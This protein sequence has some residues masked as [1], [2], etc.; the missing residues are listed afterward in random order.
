M[1]EAVGT[2]R[3]SGGRGQ[4]LPHLLPTCGPV[5]CT[6][7]LASAGSAPRVLREPW[8]QRGLG[9]APTASL[10]PGKAEVDSAG[11]SA[12]SLLERPQEATQLIPLPPDKTLQL[13][14][15]DSALCVIVREDSVILLWRNTSCKESCFSPQRE[16]PRR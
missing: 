8:K 14:P 2:L 12:T 5:P 6:C 10:V 3:K 9:V 1:I 15:Q 13:C 16:Q 11:L 7:S 4:P